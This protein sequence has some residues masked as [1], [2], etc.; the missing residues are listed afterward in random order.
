MYK[1][2]ENYA[3]Q[4]NQDS[5]IKKIE[6]TILD[7]ETIA[8]F[9]AEFI[10]RFNLSADNMYKDDYRMYRTLYKTGASNRN[11]SAIGA[12]PAANTRLD[13]GSSKQNIRDNTPVI[14]SSKLGTNSIYSNSTAAYSN[15][16]YA[17][18]KYQ[19]TTTSSA[20]SNYPSQNRPDLYRYSG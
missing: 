6:I 15:S 17:A 12:R 5:N 20:N 9:F 3:R 14:N 19:G 10:K 7:D 4:R 13:M 8:Y 18:S 16:I 1:V 2:L 11:H